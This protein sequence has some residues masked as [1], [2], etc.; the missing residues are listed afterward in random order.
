MSTFA[1]VVDGQIVNNGASSSTS[2]ISKA[3]EASKREAG[4]AL[5]KDAFLQLLVT[6][7]QYQD[8]LEPTDN[9]E[10]VSQLATF[11]TLEEMQNMGST[12][13]KQS[14]SALVGQYVFMEETSA[15]GDTKTIEGTVDYVTFSGSKTY[16]SIDGTL[17]DYEDLKTVADSDYTLAV[18]LADTII[19]EINKLP[20]LDNLTSADA[21]KVGKVVEAYS[22][23]NSYQK[24]FLS[25]EEKA[26]YNAYATWYADQVGAVE[27]TEQTTETTESDTNTETTE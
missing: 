23:M 21:E 24:S 16:L 20:N 19:A 12:M 10:Y 14:A 6:Q 4:G 18:K 7:M 27:N 22:A 1:N 3:I 17:Y 11:S 13:D 15:T 9:T 2:S 25:D 26:V 8:P 5:D